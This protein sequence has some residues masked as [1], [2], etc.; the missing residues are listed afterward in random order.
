VKDQSTADT[1]VLL[2]AMESPQSIE[3][4]K[5]AMIAQFKIKLKEAEVIAQEIL[6]L[7]NNKS[8]DRLTTIPSAAIA[9]LVADPS[10]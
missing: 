1:I 6:Q 9:L 7:E 2:A 8:A 4:R 5:D 3:A 10:N